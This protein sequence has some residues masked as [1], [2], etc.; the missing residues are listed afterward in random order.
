MRIEDIKNL[1]PVD[2]YRKLR[3]EEDPQNSVIRITPKERLSAEHFA[4]IAVVVR[5]LGGKYVSEDSHFEIPY[6]RKE[7]PFVFLSPSERKDLT[8]ALMEIAEFGATGEDVFWTI[9]DPYYGQ[10]RK[11]SQ[12]TSK[13][14]IARSTLDAMARKNF[15]EVKSMIMSLSQKDPELAK[16]KYLLPKMTATCPSC[17]REIYSGLDLC[18]YCKSRK[19]QR[20]QAQHPV[21]ILKI[22]YAK[23]EITKEE[24]EEMKKT[25]EP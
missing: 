25:L 15:P 14:E 9:F 3:C 16:L 5:L 21:E 10:L 18:P 11:A 1:L 20:K 4:K 8:Y 12:R 7:A 6:K 22:R 24:Y 23:G 17:S 13:L 19:E 2:T